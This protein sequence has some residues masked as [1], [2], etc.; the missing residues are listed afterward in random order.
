MNKLYKPS[1]QEVTVNDNSLEYALS[2]GWSKTDPTKSTKKQ[3]KSTV[4][5]TFNS[6]VK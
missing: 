2:I 4:K 5:S 1:G 3:S 6:K